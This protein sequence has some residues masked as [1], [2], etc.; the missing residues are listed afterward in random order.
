MRLSQYILLSAQV[1][2]QVLL[3]SNTNRL[4]IRK[5]FLQQSLLQGNESFNV[6]VPP[7]IFRQCK[8]RSFLMASGRAN[9]L[10]PL[11]REEL[12]PQHA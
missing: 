7:P 9:A 12:T 6:E 1:L 8:L 5:L 4:A 2:V 3:E 11:E 10:R